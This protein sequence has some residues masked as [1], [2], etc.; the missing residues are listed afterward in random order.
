M[1]HLRSLVI[2]SAITLIAA[3]PAAAETINVTGTADNSNP[4]NGNQCPSIRS[5]LARAEALPGPD[6]IRIPP[7]DHVITGNGLDIN[8]GTVTLTGAGMGATVIVGNPNSL[9]STLTIE[10]NSNEPPVATVTDLTL[11][12]GE[13]EGSGGN[14]TVSEATVVLDRVRIT[15]GSAS[16]GGGLANFGGT[17]TIRRSVIEGNSAGRGGGIANVGGS[18]MLERTLMDGNEGGSAGGAILNQGVDTVGARLTVRDT[19]LA[20]NSA[21]RGGAIMSEDS[22]AN[23]V[24]LE[25][26]TLAHNDASDGDA[27]GVLNDTGEVR[28]K[29]SILANVQTGDVPFNCETAE[30]PISEGGNIATTDDCNLTG[31]GD[32]QNADPRLA[33]E[34]S[35]TGANR[36]YALLAG[37]PAIDRFECTG[38]DQRGVTRPQGPRCDSGAYE[39]DLVPDTIVNPDLS[40]SSTEPGATFECALEGLTDFAPCTSPYSTAGLA[41]GTYTLLVRAVD[42]SGQRDPSPARTTFTVPGQPTPEPT[43]TPT[44]EPT[45]V[46][47]RQVV[48]KPVR[49]TVLI[50][51]RRQACRPLRAGEAIPIGSTVD[52]KK[53]EVELTSLSSRNGKPQTARFRDG[54]FRISQSGQVTVLTLTEALDC[55]RSRASTAQKKRKPKT[56]KLWGNGKGKFRVKGQY[57]AATIRGTKWLVQ[58]GCGYTRTKVT[59]GSVLVRDQVRKR[60]IVVRRGKTYTA[61]PR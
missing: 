54:I 14:M 31:P 19:T 12:G 4:C 22:P 35:G 30:P 20:G 9:E 60:N 55:R 28:L 15:E 26:A 59:V 18:V 34:I 2:A 39:L 42:P 23:A 36:T 7:G 1:R 49:G 6:T 33:A 5:A 61:R 29:G 25:R 10:D 53:G 40:F 50:C 17:V 3:A 46:F 13:S 37:S 43:P 8:G 56:R 47:G 57:S 51:L 11:R 16:V 41:P 58:D 38:T 21:V 45:P 32:L 44:P 27:G 52:T 48:V 24:R